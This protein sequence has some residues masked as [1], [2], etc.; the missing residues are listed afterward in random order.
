MACIEPIKKYL[1]NVE[2]GSNWMNYDILANNHMLSLFKIAV[3]ENY[4]YSLI[5]FWLSGINI[6]L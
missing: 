1:K 3:M 5:N 2:I 4:M 6:T